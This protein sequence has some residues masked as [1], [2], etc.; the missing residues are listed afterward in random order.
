M[1]LL[2]VLKNEFAEV[3]ETMFHGIE[4]QRDHIFYILGI[5]KSDLD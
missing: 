5:E 1:C 2:E 3:H 4:R